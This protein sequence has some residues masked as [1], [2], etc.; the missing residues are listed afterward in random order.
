[1]HIL[2]ITVI[3]LGLLFLAVSHSKKEGGGNWV[4]FFFK[5][6]EAGF[7]FREIEILRQVAIQCNLEFPN[8]LFE[9]QSQFDKC[10]RT[11]IKNIR[12]SGGGEERGT[13]DFLS[14]L[15]N[16][17]Q[18]IE[19]NKH[20][21]HNSIANSRLI[22][23]G[24]P[25]RILVVGTGVFKSQVVKNAAQ[26]LTIARP[27]NSKNSS[28]SWMGLK[29]S[30]YFWREDDA[31]YVFDSEVLDEVYSLGI[32]SLKITHGDSLFR[33]Q[34]RKSVRVKMH[35]AAFLYLVSSNEP[36]HRLAADPGLKCLLEDLSDT[37]CGVV[38]AGRADAGLRV[39]VQFAL[40][41]AAVC[42]TGTIRSVSFREDSNRS[43]LHIEAESLP[44]EIR[45]R[46]LGE[47]FG[48]QMEND[49]EEL[50]FHVFD[51]GNEDETESFAAENSVS[52]SPPA[53]T[54]GAMS[55]NV[56]VD[57]ADPQSVTQETDGS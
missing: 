11:L 21:S 16:Y 7:S 47:V 13:Q 14:K 1:L 34:K 31:G 27:V 6:K 10:L 8:T 9:S 12:M 2:V 41:N 5:G 46:I 51:N 33:T 20:H 37:G 40:N 29:I 28:M 54:N 25:L 55:A 42:M 44:A 56:T 35:K 43:V 38:V 17:R 49:D 57:I 52:E 53:D 24:Q 18:K 50:P 15:Y 26:F 23:E 48:M 39:K 45:N 3:G 32:P 4:Q 30:V 19:L 36:P 22:S